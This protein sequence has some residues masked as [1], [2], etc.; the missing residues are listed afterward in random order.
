MKKT[1][2]IVLQLAT[3]FVLNSPAS[4]ATPTTLEAISLI[5][6]A[7]IGEG[8]VLDACEKAF[9]QAKFDRSNEEDNRIPQI[10]CMR[11]L[12]TQ[13]KSDLRASF[14]V[15]CQRR[16]EMAN[17]ETEPGRE[18]VIS[19]AI[20]GGMFME[21]Y[22]AYFRESCLNHA[23]SDFNAQAATANPPNSG[24]GGSATVHD[25]EQFR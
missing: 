1:S 14:L 8:V 2:L 22:G 10:T 3:L 13:F 24:E 11:E 23:V 18:F 19:S 9:Q 25:R 20:L 4:L 17:K 16:I 15:Q 21:L 6:P 12:K 5:A 7:A